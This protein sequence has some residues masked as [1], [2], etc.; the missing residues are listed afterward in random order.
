MTVEIVSFGFGHDAPPKAHVILDLSE[1]FR[2]PHVSPALR[3]LT[4]EDRAVRRAVLRT[5][6]IRPLL[7]ATVRQVRA[8]DRGPSGGS[9]V[10]AV[11][12]VG[13]RHRSATVAHYL[14]RRLRRRGL[15]VVLRHRDL[16][17]PVLERA[18]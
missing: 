1:H 11:G 16:R 13:G 8:F 6:G 12:C 14:A 10:V 18:A 7:R 3:Y 5:A 17:R 15:E 9:I 2:D 4:A